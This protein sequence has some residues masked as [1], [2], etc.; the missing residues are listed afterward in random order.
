MVLSLAQLRRVWQIGRPAVPLLPERVLPEA[1]L[2]PQ[3]RRHLGQNLQ[4]APR[5][6]I[7]FTFYLYFEGLIVCY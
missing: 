2:G 7:S 1:R 4:R 6:K 5:K 3:V